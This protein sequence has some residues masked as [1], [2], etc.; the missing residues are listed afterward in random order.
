MLLSRNLMIYIILSAI[1]TLSLSFFD[2]SFMYW[3]R[4]LVGETV[5]T[6]RLISFFNSDNFA[7]KIFKLFSIIECQGG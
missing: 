5:Y 4:S 3:G 2:N 1:N 6:K 7:M